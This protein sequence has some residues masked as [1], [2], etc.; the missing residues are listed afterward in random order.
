MT[1]IMLLEVTN[2]LY[3]GWLERCLYPCVSIY[4]F[5][6]YWDKG[7][8]KGDLLNET[9]GS[10]QLNSLLYIASASGGLLTL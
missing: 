10:V 3:Y 9:A 4:L 6:I 1:C 5:H 8:V 7:R 2:F